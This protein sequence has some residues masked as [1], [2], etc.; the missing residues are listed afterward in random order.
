MIF[1]QYLTE[2][3]FIDGTTEFKSYR[4]YNKLITVTEPNTT[5]NVVLDKEEVNFE[6]IVLSIVNRQEVTVNIKQVSNTLNSY[7]LYFNTNET[8]LKND[9]IEIQYTALNDATSDLYS[10]DYENGILYLASTPNINLEVESDTYNLL[11]TGKQGYQLDS[12]DYTFSETVLTINNYQPLNTYDTVYTIKE[13]VNNNYTT[14]LLTNIK[15]N[16]INTSEEES[17]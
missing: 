13:D 16:Y 11:C 1:K 14:Q 17:L 10:V 5:L 6:S 2:V 9:I 8:F 15:I 12:D 3:S 4:G 7:V